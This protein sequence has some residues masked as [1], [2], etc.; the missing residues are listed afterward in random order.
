MKLLADVLTVLRVVLA[1][2][3]GWIALTRH[4]A[5]GFRAL[6]WLVIVAFTTDW[7]DGPIA[8]RIRNVTQTWL[9]YHDFEVDLT[10]T[11]A[12]SITLFQYQLIWPILLAI[13]IFIVWILWRT[14]FA[15]EKLDIWEAGIWPNHRRDTRASMLIEAMMTVIDFSFLY[16]VWD[17][18]PEMFK[19]VLAWIFAVTILNPGRSLARARGFIEVGRRILQR[20]A[21]RAENGEE[22]AK[23][24]P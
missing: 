5:L 4:D 11:I 17:Q 21:D 6:T 13:A 12:L 23:G 7:L 3:I 8:R 15:H 14:F 16:L 9:G 20:K 19:I 1:V 24:N 2:L 18:D 22:Q 10:V